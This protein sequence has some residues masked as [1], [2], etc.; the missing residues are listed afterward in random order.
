[1]AAF[2]QKMA[3]DLELIKGTHEYEDMVDSVEEGICP[4]CGKAFNADI[5]DG[6]CPCCGKELD[7]NNRIVDR[8]LPPS[9]SDK[10]I[11]A[12]KEK[13]KYNEYPVD[14]Y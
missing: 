8:D 1:M 10:D 6:I 3:E 14:N 13:L 7:G 2:D 4:Y 9:I 5:T 12:I 11:I